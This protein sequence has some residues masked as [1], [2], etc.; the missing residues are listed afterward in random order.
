MHKSTELGRAVL[1]TSTANLELWLRTLITVSPQQHCTNLEQHD[2]T[3][4]LSLLSSG[5]VWVGRGNG[6]YID[7]DITF[8]GQPLADEQLRQLSEAILDAPVWDQLDLQLS[9]PYDTTHEPGKLRIA[10]NHS[11][12]RAAPTARPRHQVLSNICAADVRPP[13]GVSAFFLDSVLLSADI[14]ELVQRRKVTTAK[15]LKTSTDSNGVPRSTTGQAADDTEKEAPDELLLDANEITSS[16]A[17]L[18]TLKRIRSPASSL[19]R[20]ASLPATPPG[21]AHQNCRLTLEASD[22][23]NGAPN[24]KTS[25]DIANLQTL[26]DGALRLSVVSSINSKMLPGVKVKANT[27]GPGLADVAPTLWKPGYSLSLCQRANLLPIISRS[28]CQPAV[29]GKTISTSLEKKLSAL[30][31]PLWSLQTA[32]R[33]LDREPASAVDGSHLASCI[34]PRLWL[35]LQTNT[36]CKSATPLQSFVTA[37]P[38]TTSH[39]QSDDMLE[40]SRHEDGKNHR[41]RPSAVGPD[42]GGASDADQVLEDD[43][44]APATCDGIP[45]EQHLLGAEATPDHI[46]E[47]VDDELLL[48]DECFEPL[49]PITCRGNEIS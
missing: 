43:P 14:F 30:T 21:E 39:F 38:Q 10:V 4:L 41:S 35:H 37:E 1:S 45:S 8:K 23:Q 11:S 7:L 36:P 26:I 24:P 6:L 31:A 15:R 25:L 12:E 47:A 40:E 16:R 22:S 3:S 48:G 29:T 5:E 20:A 9:L 27:F 13:E 46:L 2:A 19:E 17:S 42:G 32:G 33:T 49:S 44:A 18:P 28:L 34:A